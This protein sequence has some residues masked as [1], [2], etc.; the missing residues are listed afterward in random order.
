MGEYGLN[1]FDIVYIL[2]KMVQY[3]LKSV[4]YGLNMFNEM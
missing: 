1:W 2:K 3:G 4:E